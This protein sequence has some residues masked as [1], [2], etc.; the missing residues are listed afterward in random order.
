MEYHTE[1]ASRQ[2]NKR[3]IYVLPLNIF[4]KNA[5]YARLIKIMLQYYNKLGM[6]PPSKPNETDMLFV[7]KRTILRQCLY[8][9]IYPYSRRHS[10][11]MSRH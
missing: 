2:N 10:E 5:S 4:Y 1:M 3:K 9:R 7:R 8:S 11:A 6:T